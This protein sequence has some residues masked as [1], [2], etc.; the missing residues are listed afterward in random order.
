MGVVF[1][2]L[3]MLVTIAAVVILWKIDNNLNN[4][5]KGGK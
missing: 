1:G 4:K 5:N 3:G 2:I